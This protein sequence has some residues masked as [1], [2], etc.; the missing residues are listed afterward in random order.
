MK[1]VTLK[2]KQNALNKNQQLGQVAKRRGRP[3][4]VVVENNQLNTAIKTMIDL[5]SKHKDL[6]ISFDSKRYLVEF[7]WQDEVYQ[8]PPQEV[9]GILSA[10][11]YLD[12]RKLK[13]TAE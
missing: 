4:K 3:P 10:M 13:W 6:F 7:M 2:A 8:V 12:D 9:E 11:K 5:V 1:R